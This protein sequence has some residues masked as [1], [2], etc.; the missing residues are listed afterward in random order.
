M[1]LR[2]TTATE[3]RG[4]L[5]E[6]ELAMDFLREKVEKGK[7]VYDCSVGKVDRYLQEDGPEMGSARNFAS[8]A[9]HSQ[10]SVLYR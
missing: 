9:H 1:L 5:R 10:L 4:I 6:L 7:N 2:S 8:Q 3:Q